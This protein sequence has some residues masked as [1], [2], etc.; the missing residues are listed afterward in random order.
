MLICIMFRCSVC[1]YASASRVQRQ[2]HVYHYDHTVASIWLEFWGDRRADPEGLR[3]LD[4]E[5]E[6]WGWVLFPTGKRYGEGA[7][8]P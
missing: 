2:R 5:R 6:V 7:S 8:S 1:L 3:R 4:G